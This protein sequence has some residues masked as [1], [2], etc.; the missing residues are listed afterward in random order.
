MSSTLFNNAQRI[1]KQMF[2]WLQT[3][4][5]SKI[6]NLITDTFNPGIN[7]AT[8]SGEGFIIVPGNNN[9][10]TNPSVNVTLG[11]IAYDPTG[12]R[13]FIDSLD[14][15]L[16][17]ANNPSTMTPD[18]TGPFVL[19][20][21]STGVINVPL[22][23]SPSPTHGTY[24]LW[25][26][27]LATI[28]T[29][30]FTLNKETNAK[31]FWKSTDGYYIQ[32]NGPRVGP[33]PVPPNSNSIFL[34]A[35]TYSGSAIA[36]SDIDQTGRSFYQILPNIVPIITPLA[37]SSD[38]TPTYA[39]ASTYTLEAHIKSVGTGTG[40]SPFNPHNMSLGDLGVSSLDLVQAHRQLE[41]QTV[42]NSGNAAANSIIAGTPG[43]PYPTTSAMA[44]YSITG[45]G[46]LSG[47]VGSHFLFSTEF[48]IING[49]A[50]NTNTI[51]GVTPADAR[52]FL[53][54]TPGINTYN[55]FWDSVAKVFGATLADIS[56][57][58]TK[59]WLCS[60]VYTFVGHGPTNTNTVANL[61]DYRR[62]GSTTHL[63]Q[64][65]ITS[66]RPG[67]G[68]T[69]PLTGEFG[70]NLDAN[71]LEFWDGGNWVQIDPPG[72][73]KDYAGTVIQS[74][75]LLC[76]GSS[77]AT[78]TYPKLFAAIG[79]TWGGAGPNFNIPDMRRRVAVGSGGAGT[80]ELGNTTGNTGGVE[81]ETHTH[82]ENSHIHIMDN[83]GTVSINT[84]ADQG[85]YAS[86]T[87][88]YG[89][90]LMAA[91]NTPGGTPYTRLKSQTQSQ[92]DT[93]MSNFTSNNFQPS[94]VV[95]K[96]IKF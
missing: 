69:A 50:F 30:A 81:A 27:Y 95:T 79:Y 21:Q 3:S 76:D 2:D 7:N 5:Q 15:T 61:I 38:R 19:T 54:D 84:G 59:L 20:P 58:T 4:S 46:G 74:G 36:P 64:R 96:I 93:G 43:T 16:Y 11:G 92:S 94:A 65:W 39:A 28:D 45:T 80:A 17:N 68:S 24:D 91:N 10:S 47:S 62:V 33:N 12:A 87:G 42:P 90:D 41:H 75:W 48:A 25:I 23:P 89:P 35:V 13:I 66:A 34:A 9:T 32:F 14:T 8:L 60:V 49:S 37:N 26:N 6:A 52:I 29:S 67:N 88:A 83:A 85:I 18:G 55:I 82:T 63:L 78:A 51:Y 31:Q 22:S 71:V 70:F 77:Y 40:I 73:M 53:P 56:S 57:D 86:G 1:I 44:C 72:T